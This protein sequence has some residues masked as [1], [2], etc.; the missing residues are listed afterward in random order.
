MLRRLAPVLAAGALC[1]AAQVNPALF[2]GLRWR[3]VGPM[4][5]GRVSAVAGV[6]GQPAHFYMGTPGGGVW[7]TTDAGTTWRPIFDS[8]KPVDS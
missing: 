2:S 6:I 3:N 8:V 1:A 5:A 7:E 4:R